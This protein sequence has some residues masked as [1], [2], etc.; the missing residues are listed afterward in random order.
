[1][2]KLTSVYLLIFFTVTYH[3]PLHQDDTKN[4]FLHGI[5]DEKVYME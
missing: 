3:W 4:A 2:N 5:L 1:V